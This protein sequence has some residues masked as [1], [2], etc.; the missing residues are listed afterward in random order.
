VRPEPSEQDEE[1]LTFYRAWITQPVFDSLPEH[2]A[3]YAIAERILGEL[4]M[5]HQRK[6]GR[7]GFPRNEGNETPAHQDFFHV[8]GTADTYTMWIPLGDC[9]EALG[10]LSIADGTHRRGFIEHAPSNGPGGVAVDPGANV[11]WRCQDFLAGDVVVFHSLTM[12]RALPNR[13]PDQVRV[14]LDN[15][16]QRVDDEVDDRSMRPHI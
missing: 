10:C 9:P 7:V 11:T 4:V 5:V 1:W 16:Y 2:P 15:R 6:I 8:R 3:L 12:H 13:T 14:S